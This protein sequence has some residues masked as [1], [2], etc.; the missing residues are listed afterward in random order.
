MIAV[1][2]ILNNQIK[3]K[4]YYILEDDDLYLQ[5]SII[6]DSHLTLNYIRIKN[7]YNV[8]FVDVINVLIELCRV[9]NLGSGLWCC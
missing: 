4:F 2:Y 7:R 5:Y 9:Y 8:K 1:D 6:E 3:S